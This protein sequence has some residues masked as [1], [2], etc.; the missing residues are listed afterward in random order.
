MG[1]IDKIF[2]GHD[3]GLDEYTVV[4]PDELEA[5]DDSDVVILDGVPD[6]E[7]DDA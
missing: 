6:V 2:P 5:G 1:L 3:H 4:D 7:D